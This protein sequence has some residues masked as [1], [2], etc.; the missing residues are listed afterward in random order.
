MADTARPA[1]QAPPGPSPDQERTGPEEHD[2]L[3]ATFHEKLISLDT[4]GL[5]LLAP[6]AVAIAIIVGSAVLLA[7]RDA[8]WPPVSVGGTQAV[9]QTVPLPV[10][11]LATIAMI[12]AWSFI[13]AGALHAH[14]ALR[15]VGVGAYALMGLLGASLGSSLPIMLIVTLVVLSVVAGAIGLYVT[16]RGNGRQAPHL[17]HRAGLRVPTFGW[18]LLATTLIYGLLALRGLQDGDLGFFIYFE[19]DALQFVL[20]PVL[21]FSATDFAEWAEVV[22]GR[23]GSLVER[24]PRAAVAGALLLAGAAILVWAYVL[25]P[26]HLVIRPL[27]TVRALAPVAILA[28]PVCAVGGFALRRPLS[29]RVPFWALAAGALVLYLG[30]GVATIAHAAE[31]RREATPHGVPPLVAAERTNAPRYSLLVPQ[32][33]T[34]TPIDGG[35]VWSGTAGGRPVRLVLLWGSGAGDRSLSLAL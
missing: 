30:I 31:A 12:L 3:A 8:G 33:W 9:L 4:M 28:V 1:A 26:G 34:R 25:Q 13:L 5:R 11:V 29:T 10:A 24:L 15:L 32:G 27:G 22:A 17:H 20:F 35:S 7:T 6:T 18:I 16:D 14:P 23:V 21:L 19:L 2:G